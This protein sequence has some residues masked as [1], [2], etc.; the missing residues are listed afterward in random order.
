VTAQSRTAIHGYRSSLPTS[1]NG[2]KG[3]LFACFRYATS[4]VRKSTNVDWHDLRSGNLS[5]QH[6]RHDGFEKFVNW[7]FEEMR[8][9]DWK[10]LG[11]AREIYF[12]RVLDR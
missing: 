2:P 10:I 5:S 12:G 8:K 11:E 7:F 6:D 4:D 9:I 1:Y 3:H